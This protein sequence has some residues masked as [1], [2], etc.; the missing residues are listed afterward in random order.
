MK[1]PRLKRAMLPDGRRVFCIHRDEVRGVRAQAE[2]Y[3]K[4]GVEIHTG[5]L[6]FDVGANI[7]LFALEA[8]RKGATVHAFEP[9][10]AT[11]AAL[12]ANV[13]EFAPGQ[14]LTHNRA[15]G[16]KSEYATFTYFPYLSALSTRFPEA[17]RRDGPVAIERIFDDPQ[18]T[19]RCG[20]FRGAPQFVRGGVVNS[21]AWLLFTSRSVRCRVETLSHQL[22]RLSVQD[23]AL[24]KIDVE[25]AEMSVLQGIASE[26]WPKIAQVVAEVHDENGRLAAMESLLKSH[27]FTHVIAEK[28]P[29]AGEFGIYL[30]WAH[31]N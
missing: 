8:A 28:E 27:G 19:P 12:E 14:V 21:L 25:G 23:I 5:D 6:V 15:L 1:K 31:R 4:H 7:G 10:P 22:K 11:F 3:L 18:M 30:L 2:G 16:E 29:D 24:L 9:M 26:D 20:W 13:A 17:A